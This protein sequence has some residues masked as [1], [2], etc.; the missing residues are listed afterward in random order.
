MSAAAPVA[1]TPADEPVLE[2]PET[3]PPP[4]CEGQPP[5]PQS[6]VPQVTLRPLVETWATQTQRL[7]STPA[8]GAQKPG[9]GVSVGD[10]VGVA[11]ADA[12]GIEQVQE[13]P[14]T[15]HQRALESAATIAALEEIALEHQV[16]SPVQILWLVFWRHDMS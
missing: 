15:S 7:S 11:V 6:I 16:Q 12:A 8:A 9:W 5:N 3:E 2:A 4:V 1:A 13:L 14:T 10:G